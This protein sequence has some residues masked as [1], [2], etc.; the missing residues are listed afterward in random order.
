MNRKSAT[1]NST[2]TAAIDMAQD[3][4]K[5]I[6]MPEPSLTGRRGSSHG[7]N[8]PAAGRGFTTPAQ[9]GQACVR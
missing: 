3:L 5:Y 6:S 1:V 9:A 2:K 7:G 4:G 8:G